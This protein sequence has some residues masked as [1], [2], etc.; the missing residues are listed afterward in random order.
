MSFRI[1]GG[2]IPDDHKYTASIP[3][4]NITE[5]EYVSIPLTQHVGVMCRPV[6]KVP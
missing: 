2:I 6:V 4:E 1:K 3:V 5:P